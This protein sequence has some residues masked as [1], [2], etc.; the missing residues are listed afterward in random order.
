M[1]R[2]SSLLIPDAVQWR[3]E[4]GYSS[5]AAVAIQQAY[6]SVKPPLRGTTAYL[7]AYA[8]VSPFMTS[9]VSLR[10]RL[11]IVYIL[12]MAHT[13]TGDHLRA[14]GCLDEA[15]ELSL[16]LKD[17]D[18]PIELF[19]LRG[20]LYRTHS[21]FVP[22]VSDF[23]ACLELL[24]GTISEQ[25]DPA[26][27][28]FMAHVLVDKALAHFFLAQYAQ[29]EACLKPALSI[30][31]D[32]AS[33]QMTVANMLWTY[34]LLERQRGHLEPALNHA[35]QTCQLYAQLGSPL[36]LVRIQILC[37]NIALD[38]AE[39]YPSSSNMAD[40]YMRFA[41]SY[42][43]RSTMTKTLQDPSGE[44]LAMLLDARFGRVA[45]TPAVD[46]LKVIAA[47]IHKAS[48]LGDSALLCQAYSELGDEQ[49]AR[50][51]LLGARNSFRKALD[52]AHTYK[53]PAL[54]APAQRFFEM[55]A[56]LD[57]LGSPG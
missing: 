48:E 6:S 36:S 53:F 3:S 11:I 30:L 17:I 34:A 35:K 14:I 27:L 46:S 18:A 16:R 39:T 29:V 12:A 1:S 8:L 9:R 22:A 26:D 50:G 24:Q 23:M 21:R 7:L 32:S 41:Q 55:S 19:Y 4:P 56:S 28:T 10:Q 31:A 25:N 2:H 33:D 45:R 13:A 5:A 57:S 52:V 15:L 38:L 42:S 49:T 47:T 20:S 40:R 44:G 54:A 51:E 43:E 37:G